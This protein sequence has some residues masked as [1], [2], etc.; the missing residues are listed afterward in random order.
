ML[1]HC[2]KV[3]P[4]KSWEGKIANA[5]TDT[6][7][8]R[9]QLGYTGTDQSRE[10]MLKNSHFVDSEVEL[11]AKYGSTQWTRMGSYPVARRLL[12]K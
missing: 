7:T 2:V 11:F 9:S 10:D 4:E 3:C 5:T 12:V 8:L 1:H 6:L